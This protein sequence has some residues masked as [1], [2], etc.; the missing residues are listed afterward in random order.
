[1]AALLACALA[2]VLVGATL[3][4]TW[5]LVGGVVLVQAVLVAG[6]VRTDLAP[7]L[8]ACGAVALVAGAA[9][10]AAVAALDPGVPPD[11]LTPLVAVVGLGLIAMTVVQLARRDGRGRLTASL[12]AGVLMLA[13]VAAAGVWVGV[14]VYPAGPAALLAALAGLAVAV[15]F[16]V[17]PGPRWL[18]VVGGT[19]AAAATGLL[20]QTYAPQAADADL[21]VLPAA[22]LAGAAGLA[23]WAGLLVARWFASDVGVG[24]HREVPAPAPQAVGVGQSVDAAIDVHPVASTSQV[25]EQPVA[26]RHPGAAGVLLTAALPLVLAAP[27]VFGVGWLLLA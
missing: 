13:L 24:S 16:A 6:V 18:W 23:G 20:V 8:R 2:G 27:V 12:T 9:G 19:I 4:G 22:L 25:P 15:A 14:D 17:F 26:H 5:W 10:T 11:A 21:A 3:A 1:V 7:A